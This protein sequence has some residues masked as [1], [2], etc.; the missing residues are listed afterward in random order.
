MKIFLHFG[1]HFCFLYLGFDLLSNE[2]GAAFSLPL[3]C[4]GM[5]CNVQ[6][7]FRDYGIFFM[8]LTI[9]QLLTDPEMLKFFFLI[10]S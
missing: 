8:S 3:C 6:M 2:L 5:S 10:R 9:S 7:T 1:L 4:C